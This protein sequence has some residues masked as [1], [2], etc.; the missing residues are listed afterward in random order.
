MDR[1]TGDIDSL[2]AWQLADIEAALREA[3]SGDFA[4]DAEVAATIDKYT[5]PMP[6]RR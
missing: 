2:E 4:S 1:K 6:R 3:K 5:K